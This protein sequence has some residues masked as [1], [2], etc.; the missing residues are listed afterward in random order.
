MID[1]D[2]T[3]PLTP[4][5]ESALVLKAFEGCAESRRYLAGYE[6]ARVDIARKSHSWAR[7]NISDSAHADSNPTWVRGY[8]H[9]LATS[10]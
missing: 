9:F 7:K 1:V 4:E 10:I 3:S 2:S 6:T 8:R 5:M